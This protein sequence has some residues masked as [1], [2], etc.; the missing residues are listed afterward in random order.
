M[1]VGQRTTYER[2]Q[3]RNKDGE[4]VVV[5]TVHNLDATRGW[6]KSQRRRGVV[7]KGGR[8]PWLH[9]T[10][11]RFLARSRRRVPSAPPIPE[12]K[13]HKQLMRH[14]W[15]RRATRKQARNGD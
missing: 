9:Q 2:A 12:E 5:M 10:F 7:K 3:H 11:K 13:L 14:G 8:M 6:K 1:I 15:Y 4:Y